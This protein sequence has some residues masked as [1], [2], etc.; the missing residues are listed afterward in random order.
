[1]RKIIGILFIL[2]ILTINLPVLVY[3]DSVNFEAVADKT[4]LKPGD[5]VLLTFKISSIDVKTDGINAIEAKL[6]YDKSIFEEVKQSNI[7]GLN[8]WS[9]VYNDEDTEYNGKLLAMILS[10][11]V[12]ETEEIF[13]VKLKVK[14]EITSTTLTKQ[15]NLKIINIETNDGEKSIKD[16][17]KVVPVT[18]QF[19]KVVETE[20]NEPKPI[21]DNNKIE[22]NNIKED[23]TVAKGTVPQTGTNELIFILLFVVLIGGGAITY[24]KYKK[25]HLH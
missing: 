16:I 21:V 22:N 18:I 19:D 12:K 3:A 13:S 2:C 25:I 23:K 9:V 4:S 5:E 10:S 7:K 24:I 6:E 1:M 17:D 15:V 11:G 8:G 14:N 20:N